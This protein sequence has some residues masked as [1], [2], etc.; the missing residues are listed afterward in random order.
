MK[1]H[2]A[3]RLALVYAESGRTEDA[4]K[5][6]QALL[7]S[8]P[9]GSVAEATAQLDAGQVYRQLGMTEE[10]LKAFRPGNRAVRQAGASA[11][12]ARGTAGP[13]PRGEGPP[14]PRP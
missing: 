3:G 8:V 11:P 9:P 5:V 13:P 4:V 2:L 14:P 10:A 6:T 12:W 7:A 1:V